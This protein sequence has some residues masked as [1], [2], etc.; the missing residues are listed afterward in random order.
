MCRWL[1]IRKDRAHS[2]EGRTGG[3]V[4]SGGA[5]LSDLSGDLGGPASAPGHLEATSKQLLR[6][7]DPVPALPR[8]RPGKRDLRRFSGVDIRHRFDLYFVFRK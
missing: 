8:G 7:L 2:G 1:Q 4:G 6:G 5:F 3:D